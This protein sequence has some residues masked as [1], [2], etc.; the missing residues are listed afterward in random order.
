MSIL[1]WN[2]FLWNLI[3]FAGGVLSSKSAAH[4]RRL[5]LTIPKPVCLSYCHTIINPLPS[6]SRHTIQLLNA[7]L[8]LFFHPL[9]LPK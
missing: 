6:S 5:L 1:V 4:D 8:R 2:L 7:L 3:V 9:K